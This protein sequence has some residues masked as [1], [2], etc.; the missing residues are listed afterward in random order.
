MRLFVAIVNYRTPELTLECLRSLE[1]EVRA[2][3]DVQVGVADND[4]RDGSSEFLA[5]AIAVHGWSSWVSLLPL[6]VNGGFSAGN[7]ALLAPALAAGAEAPEFVL[8]LNPDTVVH[9][10]ALGALLEFMTA[11]PEVGI[12][13]SRVE[14]PD[15]TPQHSRYR[16]HSV[17]SELDSGL[18]L[19]LVSRLLRRHVVALPLLDRPHAADWVGGAAM[20]VR[21]TVFAD[22]GLMDTGYF[23]YFEEADFCLAARRAGWPCW[24][25]PASRIVHL[26]GQ[27]SGITNPAG[28]RLRRP[29]YW[30]ESRRRYFVKNHGRAYAWCADL[31]WAT[32]FALWRVRRRL[33][34]KPDTD[35]PRLLADFLRFRLAP[36]PL[37]T[38]ATAAP[39]TA[40]S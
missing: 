18:R 30:F 6:P 2:R 38:A 12:A 11:H 8:L 33:Q 13:G 10:R 34:G 24:Y 39:G 36:G 32:G 5:A 7:N 17:W 28:P 25:V 3:G 35:P 37:H 27:S 31:A 4:S 15:G 9:P 29:R 26:V 40:A 1:P 21:S 16:F 20:L 22:I 14:E 19:G 23:L